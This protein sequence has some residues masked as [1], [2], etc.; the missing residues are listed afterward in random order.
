MLT[1]RMRPL[2]AMECSVMGEAYMALGV[3]R[4]A[5]DKFLELADKCRK[6]G[7]C[8]T[9]LWHNSEFSLRSKKALYET[10]LSDLIK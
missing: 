1:L 6:V 8:F 3:G 2:I 4:E 10:L 7:G 9:M 5:R